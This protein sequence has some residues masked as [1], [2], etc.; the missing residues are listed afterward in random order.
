MAVKNNMLRE[1]I[2]PSITMLSSRSRLEK[3]IKTLNAIMAEYRK[4]MEEADMRLRRKEIGPNEAERIKAR[5]RKKM[6][7]LAEKIRAI[8]TKL[9]S[10]A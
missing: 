1:E 3:K 9:E 8:R 7:A 4:E 10:K 5:C 6:D 2:S